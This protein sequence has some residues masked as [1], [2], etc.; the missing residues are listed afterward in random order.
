MRAA[1]RTGM[2]TILLLTPAMFWIAGTFVRNTWIIRSVLIAAA[3]LDMAAWVVLLAGRPTKPSQRV[4]VIA[5]I[6]IG[7]VIVH[8]F[9]QH[10]SE[11][12]VD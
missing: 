5:A 11:P 8:H 12:I 4:L 9:C 3:G 10:R 1:I 7:N 2:T 6:L